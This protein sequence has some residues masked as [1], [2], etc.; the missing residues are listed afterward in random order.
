MIM[1]YALGLFR[2]VIPSFI[3]YLINGDMEI[4]LDGVYDTLGVD[5]LQFA[6]LTFFVFRPGYKT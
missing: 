2:D 1:A 5:I 3:S 6:G 4:L